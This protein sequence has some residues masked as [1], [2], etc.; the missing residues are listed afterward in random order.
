LENERLNSEKPTLGVFEWLAL[1][2]IIGLL[3]MLTAVSFIRTEKP[4]LVDLESPFMLVNPE[5]AVNVEGA[6]ESPGSYR[7]KKGSLVKEAIALAKLMPDADM[8]KI[9][10]EAKI[11][12]GKKIHVPKIQMLTIHLQGAVEECGSLQVPK[13]TRLNDLVKIAKFHADASL[14]TLQKKRLLKNNE[15]IYVKKRCKK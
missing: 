2:T 12:P 1:T 7:L 14:E 15:T 11:R 5:V 10:L 4:S 13:G 6:V 8:R 9:K 3:G